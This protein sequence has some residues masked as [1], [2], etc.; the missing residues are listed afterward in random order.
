LILPG[1]HLTIATSMYRELDRRFWLEQAEA[2]RNT[3]ETGM[4]LDPRTDAYP[5]MI[6]TRQSKP[7]LTRRRPPTMRESDICSE[8]RSSA[9]STRTSFVGS[10]SSR[11]SSR[12]RRGLL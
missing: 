7:A 12:R 5:S 1:D 3:E 11:G 2:D 10:P 8:F 4:E 9:G 6:L